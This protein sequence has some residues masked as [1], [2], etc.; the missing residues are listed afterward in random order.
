M[1]YQILFICLLFLNSIIYAQENLY[2]PREIK[3]AYKK[4][5]RSY[6]G[7]PGENYFQNSSDYT[8]KA[9]FVSETGI[10]KGQ[11]TIIYY[12]NSPDTLKRIIIRLYQ[13]VFKKGNPRS[14]PVNPDDL[15]DGVNI[16]KLRINDKNINIDKSTWQ[17]GT[18]LFVHLKEE[19][20]PLSH[21]DIE[22]EWDFE[23]P[24]FTHIRYGTYY[25]SSF[26]VAYWYPRISVYD[27]I[28]K[29]NSHSHNLQQE[30][31]N[32]YGDYDV[33]I[34][35][36]NN[37]MVW[38]SGVLQNPEELFEQ[39]FYKRYIKS[40]TSDE[41]VHIITS[42]DYESKKNIVISKNKKNIWKFKS[43]NLSDFAFAL[44]D[45]YLW[46]AVSLV[47]DKEEQRRV[48]V[49]AVYNKDSEDF[50]EVAQIGR[51]CIELLSE[52]I[53][54]IPYPYPQLTVFNGHGGME[55]PMMVNDGS[56]NIR[57]ETIFVTAHE[58]T[59]SYFPFYVGTNEQKY[60][61]IDEGL[62][63]FLP[64]DIE[65]ALS[66]DTTYSPYP[67][68]ISN[69]EYY[70]GSFIDVPMVIPSNSLRGY[71][72]GFQAY[73]RPAVAYYFLRELLGKELFNKGIK[74]YTTQWKGKHPTPYDFFFTF[75]RIS[76]QDLDWF[77]KP[78][79]FEV[80]CPDLAID[81]VETNSDSA[82]IYIKKVGNIPVPLKLTLNYKDNTT[83][84]IN[85]P[86]SIWKNSD[87]FTIGIPVTKQI[88]NVTLGDELIPDVDRK[89]NYYS[90]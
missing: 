80:G 74:E 56:A 85:K 14:Y 40:Q 11:E 17:Y 4:G 84:T 6:N 69:Y 61:F 16:S 37:Y 52:E 23:F 47:V 55:F 59:H 41:L 9:E 79:F 18:N 13:D 26:M 48:V 34:T 75:N 33:E 39:Q 89:N 31:Y 43:E 10:L 78:W 72:Y 7:K 42:T 28:E 86:L 27:D 82:L 63:T 73:S 62:V 60:A 76:G 3:Q 68:M 44:S 12:N 38:A 5:T 30:Y 49:N 83:E 81:K 51:D 32:D 90:Q 29:W 57:N 64:K 15:H 8:I 67:G 35:V 19:L 36:P 71:S 24:E 2:M 21:I 45:S 25:S 70:S 77:W 22:I 87:I 88:D 53:I 20:I 46:D 50:Y 66:K 58:I 65:I 1:K 54:G